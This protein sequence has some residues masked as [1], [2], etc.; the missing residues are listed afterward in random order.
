MGLVRW[1]EDGRLALW[2]LGATTAGLAHWFAVPVVAGLV[3]AA[4]LLHRRAALPVL[5]V[6]AVAVLPTLALVLLTQ[7]NGISDR[8]VGE[9]SPTAPRRRCS[10]CRPG[11][12]RSCCCS[13]SSCSPAPPEP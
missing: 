3:L 1:R 13:W 7:L 6:A 5:G 11:P 10:R 12:G 9:I 2:A 8:A 4:L